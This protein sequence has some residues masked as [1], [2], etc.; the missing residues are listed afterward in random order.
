MQAFPQIAMIVP[1][2][3]DPTTNRDACHDDGRM[4]AAGRQIVRG[5]ARGRWRP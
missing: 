3:F 5:S 4:S 1:A 2:Y